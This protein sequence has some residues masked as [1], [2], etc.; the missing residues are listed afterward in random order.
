M[1]KPPHRIRDAV[2]FYGLHGCST[3][4]FLAAVVDFAACTAAAAAWPAVDVPRPG[5]G[6]MTVPLTEN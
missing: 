1:K 4:A 2:V 5:G 6:K 3:V